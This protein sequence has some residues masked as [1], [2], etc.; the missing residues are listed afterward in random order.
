[1]TNKMFTIPAGKSVAFV[2]GSGCGKST[3][4][5]LILRWYDLNHCTISLDGRNIK[6]YNLQWYH[7][8]MGIVNQEPCLFNISIKENIKYGKLDAIDEEIYEAAKKANI[9]DFIMS[10]PKSM[11]HQLVDQEQPK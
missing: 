10:L 5:G 11:I 9:H 1:M 8:Q 7:K 3:I 2:G 6:D 4:I